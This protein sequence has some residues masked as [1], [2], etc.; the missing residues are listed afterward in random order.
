MDEFQLEELQKSNQQVQDRSPYDPNATSRFPDG[1]TPVGSGED[2]TPVEQVNVPELDWLEVTAPILD[3]IIP[4]DV[5]GSSGD[6][7][8]FGRRDTPEVE[9]TRVDSTTPARNA[10]VLPS[11]ISGNNVIPDNSGPGDGSPD[12]VV[13]PP[14]PPVDP[15]VDP[16]VPPVEPP[17]NP[18]VPPVDL[19]VD[20][21]DPEDPPPPPPED[22][23]DPEDPPPPP[24]EDPEDPEEPEDPEDPED[25][26]EPE[27]PP[28]PPPEDPE[29]PEEPEDPEDPEEPDNEH[30]NNGFGNGDQDAPGGSGP[31]NNAE[32]D[33]TP[34]EQ[35]NSHQ[36]NNGNG[37]NG[38]KP[39]NHQDNGWGN[40]D[41]DAPGGSQPHN[42]AENDQ[43]PSGNYDDLVGRFLE[44]NSGRFPEEN[45]I[46]VT[47]NWEQD[48]DSFLDYIDQP[49]FPHEVPELPH[50]DLPMD[51]FDHSM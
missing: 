47:Y 37:G 24:P 51:Y 42:N 20:P 49:V 36:N 32:N 28:P 25:P 48:N 12:K 43:T 33:Q 5:Y 10:N 1:Y 17:I 9:N 29:D 11:S 19:P 30:P 7:I 39:D 41:D 23:V 13:D 45:P 44:E 4:Q 40:G 2:H 21:V 18:P 8:S 3:D 6:N 31:N 50:F 34:G 22:P 26:E 16:P 15:P 14:V 46:D 35:G 38:G 27:D